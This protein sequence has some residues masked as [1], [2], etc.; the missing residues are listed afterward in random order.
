MP[1]RSEFESTEEGKIG[2]DISLNDMNHNASVTNKPIITDDTRD[3]TDVDVAVESSSFLSASE[4]L[5]RKSESDALTNRKNKIQDDELY[6]DFPSDGRSSFTKKQPRRRSIHNVLKSVFHSSETQQHEK[7]PGLGKSRRKN[8]CDNRGSKLRNTFHGRGNE[9][10][11]AAFDE[12]NLSKTGPR[13]HRRRSRRARSHHQRKFSS[14]ND[15]DDDKNKMNRLKSLFDTGKQF[16]D[17]LHVNFPKGGRRRSFACDNDE[18]D[19]GRA[20]FSF[21]SPQDLQDFENQRE[22]LKEE[23]E[24]NANKQQR[25]FSLPGFTSCSTGTIQETNKSSQNEHH[26][27]KTPVNRPRFARRASLCNVR[28]E[29]TF[30]MV[31]T[32]VNF[33]FDDL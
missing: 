12:K 26:V 4:R 3:W 31:A 6:V 32:T 5:R 21:R 18:T 22:K 20:F 2:K 1:P 15:V 14:E 19:T 29:R 7:D 33:I 17:D 16:E 27:S 25:R 10:D 11:D 23:R 9:R 28:S 13:R 8:S 30:M 24:A